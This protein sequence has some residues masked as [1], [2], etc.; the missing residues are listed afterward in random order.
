MTFTETPLSGA[1]LITPSSRSDQRGW[2]M[3][4]YD[5]QLFAQIGHT[6]DWVQMNHSSTHQTGAVRGMHFQHPPAAEI[7]LVRC[8]AG[9]VFDV[10]VDLR[11]GSLTFGQWFGA[12]LSADNQQMLY[13]PQ[14][15]AHGFQTLTTDCQL[16]YCHS[17]Y[18]TPDAE[19]AIRYN[20][21]RIG[22]T[23]PLPVTDL[24][25]RDATHPYLDADYAG[26]TL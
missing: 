17:A 11:Q 4:T 5:K 20:D 12:E 3:R 14:G 21:P 26:L 15:F 7:K 25:E 23:W 16:I 6:A 22:I 18:Y 9:I 19:G 2:F 13:I 10:I 8:V 1:Y 24:S